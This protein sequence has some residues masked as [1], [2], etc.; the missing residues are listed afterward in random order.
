MNLRPHLY[1][2]ITACCT[3]MPPAVFAQWAD[4]APQVQQGSAGQGG[5]MMP[6]AETARASQQLPDIKLLMQAAQVKFDPKRETPQAYMQRMKNIEEQVKLWQDRK[7]EAD[8]EKPATRLPEGMVLPGMSVYQQQNK[9][10]DN[11]F[12]K[13]FFG[14]I[15]PEQAAAGL[16]MNLPTHQQQNV[17]PQWAKQKMPVHQY[18]DGVEHFGKEDPMGFVN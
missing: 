18:V 13:G 1:L 17:S 7:A 14:G 2:L 5:Q 3:S 8:R 9:F 15:T 12:D 6:T 10:T 16:Q 4:T 11:P